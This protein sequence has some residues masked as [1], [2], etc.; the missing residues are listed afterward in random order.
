MGLAVTGY[1]V[2][3]SAG[4]GPAALAASLA[5]AGR[6]GPLP[7]HGLGGLYD[8]PSPGPSGHALVDFDVRRELARKGT[9]F[10]NRCTGLALAACGRALADAGLR[11]EDANRHRVGV[12]MGTTLGS[13]K[14]MSDYTR[15]TLVGDRPYLVNP[16]LFPNTV[17][18]CAAG[19]AAVWYGLK[20]VNTTVAGGQLAFLAV[21]RY[22]AR[23]LRCGHADVLLA[24]AV[25]EFTPHAAWAAHRAG[26]AGV[27]FGEGAAVFVVERAETARGVGRRP[28]AEVLSVVT[29]FSPGGAQAAALAGC[30]RRALAEAGVTPPELSLLA[31][32]ET[33]CADDDRVEGDALAVALGGAA[34][35]RLLVKR[36]V[37]D[38]Q[39]A[40]GA[41]QLAA[42]LA[43]HR[44]DPGRDG[45]AALVTS[46]TPEGGVGAAVLRAWSR[47]GS[48][49]R[50]ASAPR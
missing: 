29:G 24:G 27:T 50:G 42:V 35:E 36:A 11:V 23:A 39:A 9:A 17:M 6:D 12:V 22:A 44:A 7:G 28:H 13:L 32:A 5:R 41:L 43:V 37:G 31:T 40:S 25:E 10:F 20:G 33:G 21:L 2:L 1:G 47:A 48:G 26:P 46:W 45:G 38:C 16:A 30:V 4:V 15:D 49:E 8:E 14:S 34:A 19:Q 18:N 3:S